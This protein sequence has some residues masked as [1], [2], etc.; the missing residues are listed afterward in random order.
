MVGHTHEPG[1]ITQE[2]KFLTPSDVGYEYKF[3]RNQKYIVNPG[4]VGQPRDGDVR[5]SYATL[6]GDVIRWHRVNYDI[7]AVVSRIKAH[8]RID[9]RLGDRLTRGR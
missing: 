8:P 9:D 7:D 3:E 1:V 6:D 4:S 5:S 2:G